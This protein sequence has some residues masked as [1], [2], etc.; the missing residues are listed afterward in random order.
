MVPEYLNSLCPS[1]VSTVSRYPLR[2]SNSL[3]L[4]RCRT[5]GYKNSFLP[6]SVKAW[7]ALDPSIRNMPTLN[8]FKSKL[9][10]QTACQKPPSH[11]SH[12]NRSEAIHHTRM[13]LGASTLNVDLFAR[14][15]CASPACVCGNQRETTCH[16]LLH[17]PQFIIQ[18]RK[19]LLNIRD[20]IAPGTNPT[21][22]LNMNET[23]YKDI[24]LFGSD[25]LDTVNNNLLFNAVHTF[26][27]E[28]AR[29]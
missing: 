5:S 16:F 23:R 26:V 15:L 29:F 9:I 20:I 11:Y 3:Q 2:N 28:S 4:I 8:S 13:R 24:L 22:L 27:S 25:D 14:G 10:S 19:L 18:R 17:C 6:S 7:N 1:L 21:L 12:G